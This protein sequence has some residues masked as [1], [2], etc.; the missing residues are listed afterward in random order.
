MSCKY[1]VDDDGIPCFPLSNPQTS[2]ASTYLCRHCGSLGPDSSL[3]SSSFALA[4][5]IAAE[6]LSDAQVIQ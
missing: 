5:P 3:H 1:C 4:Q 6:Q 2:M